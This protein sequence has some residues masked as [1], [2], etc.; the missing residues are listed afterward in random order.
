[1]ASF[2]Q[3]LS[4]HQKK[5]SKAKE[6]SSPPEEPVPSPPKKKKTKISGQP[7]KLYQSESQG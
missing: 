3:E 7:H 5:R 1:M 6:E 2:H 4:K